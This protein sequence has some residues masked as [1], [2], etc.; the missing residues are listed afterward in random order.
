MT[1]PTSASGA[2]DRQPR[3]DDDVDVARPDPP[4]LVGPLALAEARVDERDPGVEVRAQPVDQRHRQGDLG[5]QHE[6]RPAGVERGRDRLDIDGGLAAAGHAVEQERARVARRDRRRTRSTASTWAGSQVGRRRPATAPTGRAAASGNRGRPY[7]VAEHNAGGRDTNPGTAAQPWESISKVIGALKAGETGCVK[8]GTYTA[9][10]LHPSVTGT[11]AK[12]IALRADGPGTVTISAADDAPTFDFSSGQ[13]LGYWLL[14]GL[15]INKAGHDGPAV[16]FLGGAQGKVQAMA[17]R[18][19]A[20]R[21]GRASV[22]VQIRGQAKDILCAGNRDFRVQAV[23][24]GGTRLF[25]TGSKASVVTM[26]TQSVSRQICR[27]RT[28][29][30][31]LS[32]Y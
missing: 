21:D 30:R 11:S 3:P 19:L 31:L 12:P 22:A 14:E 32:G 2:S 16:I 6:R 27:R 23:E 1:S 24:A 8:S 4:P 5:D 7:Y 10:N 9:S 28:I 20:I 18:K 13:Q 17:V 29:S 15:T 25:F 26:R